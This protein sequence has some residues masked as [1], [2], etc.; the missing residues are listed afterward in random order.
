MSGGWRNDDEIQRNGW[1]TG[2]E[3]SKPRKKSETDTTGSN[4]LG[5]SYTL[6]SDSG[7]AW[8]GLSGY[9]TTYSIY[10]LD[11]RQLYCEGSY[12]GNDKPTVCDVRTLVQG[13]Y[14]WRVTGTLSK[15]RSDI[16]WEFC[17]VQGGATTQL[18]FEI[19]VRGACSPVAIAVGGLSEFGTGLAH[20]SGGRDS[21]STA[22]G[23]VASRSQR[24]RRRLS[25]SC[26]VL[27]ADVALEQLSAR[28]EDIVKEALAIVLSAGS[29][30]FVLTK[31]VTITSSDDVSPPEKLGESVRAISVEITSEA[32]NLRHEDFALLRRYMELVVCHGVFAAELVSLAEATSVQGFESLQYDSVTMVNFRVDEFSVD[33]STITGS[34]VAM[35]LYVVVASVVLLLTVANMTLRRFVRPR[36]LDP[37]DVDTQEQ[38]EENAH[39][40]TLS[41]IRKSVASSFLSSPSSEPSSLHTNSGDQRLHESCRVTNATSKLA[42]PPEE[43]LLRNIHEELEVVNFDDIRSSSLL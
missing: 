43:L 16:A 28:Q 41:H 27:L 26:T 31:D 33:P 2:T 38:E 1:T 40:L 7:E 8:E 14:L 5:P 42:R 34:P 37:T 25:L 10:S 39:K 4:S 17:G 21:V 15:R 35:T 32:W 3:T 29:Q 36:R 20:D 11:A 19:D 30:G 24:D 12:C 23:T 13:Q 9:G 22:V 18:K 6:F